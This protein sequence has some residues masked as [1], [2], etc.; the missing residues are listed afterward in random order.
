M[1]FVVG[2]I[3]GL[4]GSAFLWL[5]FPLP[6]LHLYFVVRPRL[7]DLGHSGVWAVFGLI[8]LVNAVLMLVLLLMPGNVG[9][10]R[11]GPPPR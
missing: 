6:F 1:A 7:H 8:P 5:G 9:V 2:A 4:I 3:S 11:F 10:N